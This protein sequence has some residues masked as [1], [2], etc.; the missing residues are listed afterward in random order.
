MA[1]A[2]QQWDSVRAVERRLIASVHQASRPAG[3]R[4]LGQ[5]PRRSMQS[6]MASSHSPSPSPRQRSAP[7]AAGTAPRRHILRES[8]RA[9]AIARP[10]APLPAH[11][12]RDARRAG[13]PRSN[14]TLGPRRTA[15]V[16]HRHGRRPPALLSTTTSVPSTS[17]ECL[18]RLNAWIRPPR[19]RKNDLERCRP[20]ERDRQPEPPAPPDRGTIAQQET[21]IKSIPARLRPLQPPNRLS[22]SECWALDRI[23]VRIAPPPTTAPSIDVPRPLLQ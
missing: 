1:P 12:A 3:Q 20:T 11:F 23:Q 4:A 10:H 14:T 22:S 8:K 5:R 19:A 13:W 16:H 17:I 7:Q 2:V 9:I 6:E 21:S 15:P 18:Q